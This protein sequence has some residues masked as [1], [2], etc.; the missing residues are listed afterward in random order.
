LIKNAHE[1]HSKLDKNVK[2]IAKA[3]KESIL[4]VKNVVSV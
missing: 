4:G 3:S 1:K 2:Q